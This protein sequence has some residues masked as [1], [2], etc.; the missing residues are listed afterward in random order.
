LIA[1]VIAEP[2]LDFM[3]TRS[4]GDVDSDNS[5]LAEAAAVR[6]PTGRRKRS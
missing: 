2:A 5:F 3:A 4:S 1:P 6:K